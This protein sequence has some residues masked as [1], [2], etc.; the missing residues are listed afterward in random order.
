MATLKLTAD[1][2]N[3]R[4][5]STKPDRVPWFWRPGAVLLAISAPTMSGG[6]RPT[7]ISFRQRVDTEAQQDPSQ[8]SQIRSIP[9]IAVIRG[10]HSVPQVRRAPANAL[11]QVIRGVQPRHG[12]GR[13]EIAQQQADARSRGW[14]NPARIPADP[15]A[16]ARVDPSAGRVAGSHGMAGCEPALRW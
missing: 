5:S 11:N 2:F 4:P 1:N 9:T 14:N 3:E 7:P 15:Q 8:P 12:P 10:R 16:A 6:R 13:A